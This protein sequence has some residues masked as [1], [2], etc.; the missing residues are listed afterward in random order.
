[1][2][3]KL[4]EMQSLTKAEALKKI[5]EYFVA[6][7]ITSGEYYDG[8]LLREKQAPFYI[9]NYIA[10]PHAIPEYTKYIKR[11]GLIVLRFKKAID[12]DG[13]KVHYV[14]GIASRG[15]DHM[16]VL[17]NIAN[18]FSEEQLTLDSLKIDINKLIEHL[19]WE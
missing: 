5:K 12:W 3:I 11:N 8:I 19:A 16:D 2:E 7:E 1:M 9:G 15:G 14:I 13:N 18:S 6:N 17:S 10:I 4:Y